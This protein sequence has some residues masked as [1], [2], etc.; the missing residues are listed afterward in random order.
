MAMNPEIVILDEVTSSLSYSSEMLLKNAME[1][2]TKG[3]I[4][5]IIAHRLSTIRKCDKILVMGN[6][7]I[8]EQGNHDELLL[9]KRRVL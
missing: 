1:Q 3:K 4:C 8:S 9:K 2:I 7:E 6:G 5:F